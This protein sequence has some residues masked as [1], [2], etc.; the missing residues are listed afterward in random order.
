MLDEDVRAAVTVGEV[1][2]VVRGFVLYHRESDE[3]VVVCFDFCGLVDLDICFRDGEVIGEGG[4]HEAE[5]GVFVGGDLMWVE[6]AEAFFD[7]VDGE[8]VWVLA[9]G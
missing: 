1:D 4:W 8:G 7:G 3:P 5:D 9:F 6:D 2:A